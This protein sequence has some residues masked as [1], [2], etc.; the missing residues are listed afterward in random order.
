MRNTIF[1]VAILLLIISSCKAKKNKNVVLE[2]QVISDTST[3]KKEMTVADWMQNSI[4]PWKYFSSKMDIEQNVLQGFS[5]L[6][7]NIRMYKDSLVWISVNMIGIEG[8]RVLINKDSM[9]LM[10]KFAK[11]YTVYKKEM[12]QDLLGAP[13]NV[14]QIQNL[15]IAKPIYVLDLYSILSHDASRLDI[16]TLQPLVYFNHYVKKEFMTIDSTYIKDRTN[17][18]YAMVDYKNY[19]SVNGH[20]FPKIFQLK[21]YDGKKIVEVKLE[22]ES[23]DFVTETSFP[24]NIPSSY[25]R[26]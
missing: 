6:G 13:L 14:S 9:V 2:K 24:F 7:G 22:F 8:A 17:R 11:T 1:Y 4:K 18:H 25:E 3:K 12:I 21:A 19:E 23:P 26:K 16:Q 10:D 20:N 5:K 15:I